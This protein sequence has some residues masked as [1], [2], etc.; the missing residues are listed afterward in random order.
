[1]EKRVDELFEELVAIRRDLHMYP[2]LS[3]EEFRTSKKIS[4][5]LSKWNIEHEKDIADTG[6]MA[7][8]RGKKEGITVGAR[9]DI[10][11]LPI[12]EKNDLPFKSKNKGI[13]HAC[14][15]DVHTAIHL[16]VAKILKDMEDE[17]EGNVKIFFQPAEET[18]GGAKRMI[19]EG[20]LKDPDVSYTLALH[21][22]SALEVGK[23]KLKYDQMNAST[24]EFSINIKGKFGHAAYPEESVDSIV[25]AGHIIT[26]LQTLVSRNISPLNSAVVT[27]GQIHGGEKNNIIAGEV[28]MSGTLRALDS[29]TKIYAMDRIREIVKNTAKAYGGKGKVNFEEG[30]PALVNNNE[31]VD[32]VKETAEGILGKDNIEIGKFPTMG[33]D[34]FSFFLEKTKGAYYNIGCNNE[35]K[36]WNSNVH[37]EKFMVDEEC[38]RT[39]VMVQ[40]K[41]L[42]RLL[43]ANVD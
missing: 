42:I 28:N 1:M 36:G 34:D 38:I 29:K 30:Y 6:V 39:G 10:D 25:I 43:K 35:S 23:V 31:V 13:M 32:I 22:N 14:G 15:H 9:A 40:V 16:G 26:A 18:I 5:Y 27:L 2:E 7:I 8:I 3:Q 33:G 11:A 4:E 19:D 24:N 37:S 41:S 17:L 20:V 21:V 12:E